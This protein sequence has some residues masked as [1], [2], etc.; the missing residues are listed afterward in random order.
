MAD[1]L[2]DL[3]GLPQLKAR[4]D[5]IIKACNKTNLVF[6]HLLLSGIGGTGKT[7]I[8]RAI[9]LELDYYFV[10]FE[11]A[12]FK[13]RNQLL[14][15]LHKSEQQSSIANKKL[16]FFIDEIHR[17]SLPLQE[18]LYFPMSEFKIPKTENTIQVSEF[19]LVG[20]T[21]RPE[22]LDGNSFISRFKLHWVIERYENIFIE[23]IIA[24]QLR[25]YDLGFDINVVKEISKRAI[26]IPRL[27]VN[28]V[29]KLNLL[30]KSMSITT[31]S[32]AHCARLFKIEEI[33][34]FGLNQTHLKYLSIVASN[35]K[36]PIGLSCIAAKMRQ[37]EESIQG[38]IEPLLLEMDLVALTPRGRIITP[39]G[40]EYLG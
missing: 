28:L 24:K 32:E 21:T 35:G 18:A 39:K 31:L 23:Q 3:I 19:T 30:A 14:E 38:T 8:A 27:A 36:S 13:N 6:P 10:E 12:I 40:L 16:M 37:P 2:S 22:M 25:E 9:A 7:A 33:D 29:D 15:S 5:Y 11:A 4:A 20:A 17:L 1:K 34:E 26:G